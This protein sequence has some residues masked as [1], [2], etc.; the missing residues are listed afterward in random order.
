MQKRERLEEDAE[1]K[2]T[3]LRDVSGQL[4]QVTA[5]ISGI[6]RNQKILM[7][8][9]ISIFE[10]GEKLGWSK[11]PIQTEVVAELSVRLASSNGM[12][13]TDAQDKSDKD[14][15]VQRFPLQEILRVSFLLQNEMQESKK[16]VTKRQAVN[17][18]KL[19]QI[20]KSMAGRKLR[21][22]KAIRRESEKMEPDAEEMEVKLAQRNARNR[23]VRGI[24]KTRKNRHADKAFLEKARWV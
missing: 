13:S 15:A 9:E 2:C 24:K 11:D 20:E 8:P 4:E 6:M 21:L 1:Q 12:I 23:Y 19:E 7:L 16:K 10:I 17:K 18:R 5:L 14:W 3:E 22:D